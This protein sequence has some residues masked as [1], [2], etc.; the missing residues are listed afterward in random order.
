MTDHSGN[1]AKA[2]VFDLFGTLI[3]FSFRRYEAA[4]ADIARIV[5]VLPEPFADAFR[6]T[7][8]DQEMALL[9]W[10]QALERTWQ[11]GGAVPDRAAREGAFGQYLAF[12]REVLAPRKEATETLARLKAK[13][14]GIGLISNTYHPVP[15]LFR[16][17][18]LAEFVDVAVFSCEEGIRKPDRRIYLLTCERLGVAPSETLFV[19]DGSG[20]ELTGAVQVGMQAVMCCVPDGDPYKAE[21]FGRQEWAGSRISAF[22]ELFRFLT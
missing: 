4:L 5:G 8:Y 15:A 12:N 9:S 16:E 18:P 20:D 14:L 13:G 2:V 21:L 17:T 10:R 11:A 3:D 1:A 6:Q 22:E 7:M 19:G